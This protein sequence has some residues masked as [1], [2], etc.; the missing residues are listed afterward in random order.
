[1]MLMATFTLSFVACTEPV[2]EPTLDEPQSEEL[3]FDV[4]IVEVT[5]SSVEFIVSPSNPDAEYLCVLYDAETVEEFTLDKYL[6]ATL[7]Q[8]LEAEAREMG[9]TFEEYMPELTDKGLLSDRYYPL[10][11]SSDYYLIVFGVDPANG[12]EANTE[13]SK[14]KV[15]TLEAVKLDV[16]FDVVSEVDENSV[17]FTVTPSDEDVYWYFYTVPTAA[18]EMYTSPDGYQMSEEEFM[19]YCLQTQIAQLQQAGY[20]SDKI[21][22]A[23]FHKGKQELAT[24]GLAAFTDYTNIVAAF[25]ITSDGLVNIISNISKSTYKTGAAKRSDMTLEISVEDIEA[26]RAAIK[27]TPSNNEETFCWLCNVW[28]GKQTAE[29]VMNDIVKMYGGSM[30]NGVMLYRGVQDYTGGPG[31]QFKFTLSSPDTDY[32]VIAFGYAGGITTDPV[33]KTFRTLEAPAAT[34]TE[35]TMVASDITPYD[36]ILEVGASHNTTF[37]MPGVCEPEEWNEKEFVEQTNAA[38][39]EGWEYWQNSNGNVLGDYLDYSCYRGGQKITVSG[40]L[41]ETSVMGYV[42]AVDVK[43]G[44]VAKVHTFDNLATTKVLGSVQ[45]TIELV[46]YYSGKDENGRV[47]GDAEATAN[48]AITVIKYSNISGTRTLFSAMLGGNLLDLNAYSDTEVWASAKQ[49]WD[50]VTIAQPYSFYLADWDY[51]QTALA[52]SVD[53]QGNIGALGRLYT[54]ATAEQKGNIQELID[55][56]NELNAAQ[57]SSL[58]MPASI[59]VNEFTGITLSAEKIA[60]GVVAPAIVEAPAKAAVETPAVKSDATRGFYIRTFYI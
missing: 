5:A 25:E 28:D 18:I 49:Y 55:L 36:F 46:G 11:P 33:M 59:V 23:L 1:M 41:P 21:M 37:Y 44:Q 52:Y 58:E 42:L 13:L 15:T 19:M 51:E 38:L 45:P 16:T 56:V 24:K 4:Q 3:T 30:N 48:S 14:T 20:T 57:K 8:D 39:V 53:K 32:Y 22:N 40:M 9:M 47:F 17:K 43:T 31:S 35:F 26:M 7:F 12:Y 6:V 2:D 27:V 29:E 50:T 60:S 10:A 54:C 34:E